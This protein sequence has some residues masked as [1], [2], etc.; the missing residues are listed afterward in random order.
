MIFNGALYG[1]L[2]G[3]ATQLLPMSILRPCCKLE[4]MAEGDCCTM[5]G[6][7][8]LAGASVGVLLAA[9]VP[10]GR[11]SWWRTALGMC[12]GLM[13]IAVLRC[14]TLFTGE[15]LGLAGG[16]VGGLLLA[17]IARIL[18]CGHMQE[19][20]LYHMSGTGKAGDFKR[21]AGVPLRLPGHR[22]WLAIPGACG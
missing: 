16:L 9:V 18:V 22:Q 10:F 6:A 17:S 14:A 21:L 2:G 4:R 19:P 8:L 5:P 3:V 20:L 15:A 11:A 13:S 1:L 7:C 12:C